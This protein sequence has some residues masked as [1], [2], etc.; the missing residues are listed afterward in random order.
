MASHTH[1]QRPV[2]KKWVIGCDG[3]WQVIASSPVSR[4]ETHRSEQNSDGSDQ[5][6]SNV[7]RIIRALKHFDDSGVPQI[8]AIPQLAYYQRGAGTDTDMEDKVFGG[9]TGSDVAEHI[10]EAYG[11]LTN[12]FNPE[13]HQELAQGTGPIDEIVLLGFSRGAFTARA[14]ASLISDIGLLTRVGMEDFWGIFE[15]W[16]DQDI[17]RKHSAWFKKKF[18]NFGKDVAF[19]DPEYKDKLIAVGYF[20]LW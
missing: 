18:P 3:T 19:T 14:I 17:P 20:Q 15:D 6:P 10:R 2:G 7:V 16:K 12:N 4:F 11:M 8:P 1:V 5:I 13:T 9:F